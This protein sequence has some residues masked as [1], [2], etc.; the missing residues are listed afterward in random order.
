MEFEKVHQ[1]RSDMQGGLHRCGGINW[2]GRNGTGR[3]IFFSTPTTTAGSTLGVGIEVVIKSKKQ[4]LRVAGKEK[5]EEHHG[6]DHSNEEGWKRKVVAELQVTVNGDSENASET[7][8]DRPDG[9][10][11]VSSL[12]LIGISAAGTAIERSEIVAQSADA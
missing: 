1:L 8:V 11:K 7:V 3:R 5:I 2:S 6:R 9:E 4:C 12:P 10:E